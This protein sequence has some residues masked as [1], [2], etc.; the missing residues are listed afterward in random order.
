[1]LYRHTVSFG[2]IFGILRLESVLRVVHYDDFNTVGHLPATVYKIGS[3]GVGY[4]WYQFRGSV[5]TDGLLQVAPVA[6]AARRTD[7]LSVSLVIIQCCTD[8]R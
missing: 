6:V 7:F 4:Q 5:Q 8:Y 3:R 2:L 1:M